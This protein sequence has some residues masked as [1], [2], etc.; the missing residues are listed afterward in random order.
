MAASDERKFLI[1][2]MQGQRYAFDLASIAEVMDPVTS[3]PI[4][5]APA[6]YVGAMNFHGAIV[7]VMD[8]AAF[9]GLGRCPELEKI[10]VLDVCVAS[11]GF[12]VER[13]ARIVPEPDI[14]LNEAPD[15]RFALALLRL[16]EG[17]AILLDA[18]AIVSDA[19]SSM[20]G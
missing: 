15:M 2:F 13:V 12:L 7:A 6:C 10:I 14:E 16:P 11:L 5:L 19:E 3:W 1:F 9:L 17:E 4:P 18:D 8:L 20:A